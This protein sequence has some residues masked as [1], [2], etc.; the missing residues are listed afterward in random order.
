M[1]IDYDSGHVQVRLA[2]PIPCDV[3]T[4]IT[5][6]RKQQYQYIS[7]PVNSYKRTLV[8]VLGY[9]ISDSCAILVLCAIMLQE[10]NINIDT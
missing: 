9:S 10:E 4:H 7:I 1:I 2:L 5:A 6:R 8:R 3:R